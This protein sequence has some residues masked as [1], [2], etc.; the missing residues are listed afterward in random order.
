MTE[1]STDKQAMERYIAQ[2]ESLLIRR[3]I[4]LPRREK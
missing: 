1:Y 3:Q 2:L 4:P